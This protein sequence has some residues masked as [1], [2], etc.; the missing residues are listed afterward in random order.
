MF[1]RI[2]PNNAAPLSCENA[3]SS[4]QMG[5][6]E[7]LSAST[8]V[9]EMCSEPADA[10]ALAECE[11]FGV[12]TELAREG[13]EY[14]SD[15]GWCRFCNGTGAAARDRG[16]SCCES[17]TELAKHDYLDFALETSTLVAFE[18]TVVGRG[19]N[20]EPL[21]VPTTNIVA[22]EGTFE[23]LLAAELAA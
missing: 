5:E 8:M 12:H 19:A 16:Y 22:L 3:Y 20:M 7:V 9:C 2:H 11:E 1:Y 23:A 18:G 6:H 17:L 14:C 21:V 15:C 4:L 13:E 10:E